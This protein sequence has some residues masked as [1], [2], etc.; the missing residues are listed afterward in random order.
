MSTAYVRYTP[1]RR[2]TGA[3]RFEIA[4]NLPDRS[5]GSAATLISYLK[6]GSTKVR[7]V[8]LNASGGGSARTDFTRSHV[9]YVE[10]LLSNAGS[11][12]TCLQGTNF[13]CQ[14][15]S[16]DNNLHFLFQARTVR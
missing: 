13:T 3:R 7:T 9:R 4:F 15:K 14:G 5:R 2:L 8:S 16:K 11:S 12:F 10:V 6:N 1:G